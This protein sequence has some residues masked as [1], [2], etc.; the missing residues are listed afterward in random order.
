MISVKVRDKKIS[1]VK[2]FLNSHDRIYIKHL[3]EFLDISE[4]HA[5][6]VFKKIKEQ[7]GIKQRYLEPKHLAKYLDMEEGH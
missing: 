1:E 3:V 7:Y 4:R 2:D 5:K 6:R